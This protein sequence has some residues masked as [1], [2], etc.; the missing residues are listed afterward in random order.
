M[1]G[2]S[3][4]VLVGA[5]ACAAGCERKVESAAETRPLVR[6]GSV[7]RNVVFADSLR[8]Q[9]TVRTKN[10]A[11]VSARMPGTVDAIL[12]EE[13]DAVKKGAALFRVDQ[14]NLA[15]AVRA[16]EDDL[17]LAQAKLA[18]A[19]V[20]DEKA[21]LDEARMKRLYEAKAV[22]KDQWERTDV[23]A[24]SMSAALDAAR[25]TVT[26]ANTGLAVARKNLSDSEVRAPFD[27]VITRKYK[28]AGDYVG[29]GVPVFAMDDPNV[30]ELSLSLNAE[31]YA[32]VA[33]GATELLLPGTNG[34][35]VATKVTY[36][37]P[38]V[39]P[40]T[41]TF[42]VRATI[43]KTAA[44]APGM[45][46]DCEIVFARRRSQAVPTTAVALRGGT[47]ALFKVADGK[48]VRVPVAAGLTNGDLRE[49]LSPEL[50]DGDEIILEG[51][52]LVNEGDEVRTSHASK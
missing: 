39:N 43:A 32:K 16:A 35:T 46:V 1:M 21:R 14:V 15:N 36:K 42:E 37:S 52:L 51:M 48:V 27:G 47:D 26:K 38:R 12:V 24:K 2:K 9:G 45:I 49:I 5:L 8:V 25:A 10:S 17:R 23:A 6:V 20:Q 7:R 50:A 19:A 3:V 33:E 34:T 41:R 28:D 4:L 31:R 29:P 44:L 18:Q 13:G 30:Y 40:A 22:T 11:T